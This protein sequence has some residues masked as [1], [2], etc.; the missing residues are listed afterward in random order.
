M[1]DYLT[2]TKT[3]RFSLPHDIHNAVWEM[4]RRGPSVTYRPGDQDPHVTPDMIRACIC[5]EHDGGYRLTQM[6]EA[7]GATLDGYKT[8]KRHAELSLADV[9]RACPDDVKEWLCSG[10]PLPRIS[11]PGPFFEALGVLAPLDGRFGLSGYSFTDAGRVAFEAFRSRT[12]GYEKGITTPSPDEVFSPDQIAILTSMLDGKL[13]RPREI[14]GR[15]L[16]GL[17]AGGMDIVYQLPNGYI[18]LR[19]ELRSVIEA[20][21]YET[22]RDAKALFLML[23]DTDKQWFYT[24]FQVPPTC[25]RDYLFVRLGWVSIR[26]RGFACFYTAAGKRLRERLDIVDPVS[27]EPELYDPDHDEFA[28]DLGPVDTDD[29]FDILGPSSSG[30]RASGPS[31]TEDQEFDII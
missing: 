28:V 4:M 7:L 18:G 13:Y 17:Y 31:L 10:L 3:G 30:A 22:V 6:G 23:P 5:I 9:M 8:K 2:L 27:A 14:D 24:K 26:K 11:P 25:S 16:R 19:P 20:L 21:I 15:V 1:L 29:D 12:H